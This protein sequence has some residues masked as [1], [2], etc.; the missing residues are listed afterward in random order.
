MGCGKFFDLLEWAEES[1]DA[2]KVGY[3]FSNSGLEPEKFYV[4]QHPL[5]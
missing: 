2:F 1:R 4:P 3:E 5:A